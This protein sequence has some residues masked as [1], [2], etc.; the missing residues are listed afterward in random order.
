[1]CKCIVQCIHSHCVLCCISV[2]R[3]ACKYT[4]SNYV[5][6][7]VITW[8]TLLTCIFVSLRNGI[9]RSLCV[10]VCVCSR[11]ETSYMDCLSLM[12][13][14]RL[15]LFSVLRKR[16]KFNR[17]VMTNA[18]A[19]AWQKHRLIG[20]GVKYFFGETN[21][22]INFSMWY[23]VTEIGCKNVR[24]EHKLCLQTLLF[25]SSFSWMLFMCKRW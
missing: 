23:F 21:K 7:K 10:C 12:L 17:I 13:H 22:I 11:G 19:T 4:I 14:F 6:W 5:L 15:D 20:L 8:C 24:N 16:K 3:S 9:F 1:M 25:A 2:C 18:A